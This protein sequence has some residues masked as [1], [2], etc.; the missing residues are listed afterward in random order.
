MTN[1]FILP[2]QPFIASVL[3]NRNSTDESVQVSHSS[4]PV[5]VQGKTNYGSVNEKHTQDPYEP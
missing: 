5:G 4:E 1:Q 2:F 3:L